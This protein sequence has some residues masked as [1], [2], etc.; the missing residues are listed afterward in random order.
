MKLIKDE[1][2]VEASVLHYHEQQEWYC[3]IRHSS[4]F[5]FFITFSHYYGK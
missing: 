5:P 4:L 2:S 1:R 3:D